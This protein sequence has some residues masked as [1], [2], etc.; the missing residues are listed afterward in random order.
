MLDAAI[1]T[2]PE[3]WQIVAVLIAWI[4]DAQAALV[5]LVWNLGYGFGTLLSRILLLLPALLVVVAIWCTMLSL[6]TVPFRSGRREFLTALVMLWWEVGRSIWLF[7]V[8]FV[9]F[10]WM[11]VG[12]TW[13]L[14]KLSLSL[15]VKAIRY[16]FLTPFAFM[17]WLGRKYFKPGVPWFAFLLTIAWCALE[18]LIFTYALLPLVSEVFYDLSGVEARNVIAPILF[19][20]LFAV[21]TGSYAMVQA[22]ADAMDSKN[23]KQLVQLTIVEVSVMFFEVIFLYRELID[24]LTPWIAS[25]TG[26]RL[27]FFSTLAFASIGWIGIR[28]MTWFFFARYGTPALLAVVARQTLGVEVAPEEER[29]HAPEPDW[30]RGPINALKAEHEWFRAG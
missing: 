22:L 18:S 6:Y 25:Q 2:L 29:P 15:F 5:S 28:A 4:P 7:W 3:Q 21:I 27:G 24:A 8:G 30:W 16:V 10:F 13:G 11:L 1:A 20:F 12:W 17:D 14:V 9:R 23:Y 26:V 19:F